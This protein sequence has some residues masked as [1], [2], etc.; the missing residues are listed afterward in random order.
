VA[1]DIISGEEMVIDKDSVVEAL[2]AS[3]SIPGIFTVVKR[4]GQYLVD[5]GLVNPVPVSVLKGMGAEI[6]IAVNVL[7]HATARDKSYWLRKQGTE[8][9]K[10]PNIFHILMQSIYI[11]THSLALSAIKNADIAIE[12]EVA[13]IGPNEFSRAKECIRQGELAAQKSISQIKRQ[14]AT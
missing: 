1:T 8:A 11:G 9:N 10:E 3:I 5:G 12:P 14:L 4:E 6:T 2:R 13:H 7:P